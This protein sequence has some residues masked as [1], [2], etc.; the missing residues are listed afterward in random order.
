MTRILKRNCYL[1]ENSFQSTELSPMKK[2]GD[3]KYICAGCRRRMGKV[4]L[5]KRKDD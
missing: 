5:K 1:C 4:K 3:T 2:T